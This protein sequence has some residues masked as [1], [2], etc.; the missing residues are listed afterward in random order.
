MPSMSYCII[1]NTANDLSGCI[2]ELE[3]RG[4]HEMS[5]YELRAIPR[6]IHYAKCLLIKFDD[7]NFLNMVDTRLKEIQK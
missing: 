3:E 6:L 5:E 7:E 4:I 2:E 1:E